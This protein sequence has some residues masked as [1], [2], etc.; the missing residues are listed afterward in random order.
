MVRMPSVLVVFAVVTAWA[1]SH[2][3]VHQEPRHLTRL[4][5]EHVRLF[6]IRLPAGDATA[7]HEHLVDNVT[8]VLDAA[9]VLNELASGAS[10]RIRASHGQVIFMG[11]PM[12]Y[13]H[14]IVNT[15]DRGLR[16][17]TLE[18]KARPA[19][20]ARLMDAPLAP[21]PALAHEKVHAWRRELAGGQSVQRGPGDAP[22]LWIA[23]AAAAV[24]EADGTTER[25]VA[26]AAGDWRWAAGPVRRAIRNVEA[27][28]LP[29][30]EVEIH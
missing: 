1:Q 29:L 30:M 12:P 17:L 16:I 4:D 7:F 5:T 11:A 6:E 27:S 25:R 3:P 9:E 20:P 22:R 2:V 14:R 26:L 28:P 19:E 18:L 10:T 23:L 24:V 15:S 21:P 8:V 13:V